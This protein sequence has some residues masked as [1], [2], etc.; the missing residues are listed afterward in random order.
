MASNNLT[1][2]ERIGLSAL[3]QEL[4]DAKN[5]RSTVSRELAKTVV[6]TRA[7]QGLASRL[8]ASL[9]PT[10]ATASQLGPWHTGPIVF[11]DGIAVGG[12]A[13]LT[14]HQNGAFNFSGHMHVSGAISYDHTFVWAVRDSNVPATVYVFAR[15]GRLHGTFEAGSRDDDWGRSEI[16]PA[17]AA[18]WSAL[19]RGWS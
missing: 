3:A 8:A 18:G 4:E 6:E 19:V 7:Q 13:D 16:N 14:L 15:A 9:D 5:T 17:L 11:P 1:E 10:Y 2:Q 12:Y